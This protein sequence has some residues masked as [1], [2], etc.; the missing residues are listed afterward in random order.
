VAI[1]DDLA[2]QKLAEGDSAEVASTLAAV[3]RRMGLPERALAALRGIPD[4]QAKAMLQVEMARCH[5]DA[6]EPQQAY[7]V[8]VEALGHLPSGVANDDATCLLAELCVQL[9]KADQAVTLAQELLKQQGPL[10][11]RGCAALAK[12]H[13]LKQEYAKA[14]DALAASAPQSGGQE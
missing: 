3:Y 8:L 13:L 14:A 10:R 5:L 12:A 9:G 11:S 1:L 6:Q 7:S 4:E 2:R